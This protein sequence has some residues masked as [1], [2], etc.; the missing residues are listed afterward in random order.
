VSEIPPGLVSADSPQ[1]GSIFGPQL[2]GIYDQS[3]GIV[4]EVDSVAAVEYARDYRVSDYPQEKG[5][6]ES[7][8][9]VQ[10]PFRA[11]VSFF[12]STARYNF[13]ANIENAVASLDLFAVFVPEWSYP[14]ANLT[15]YS[16]RREARSGVTLIRVDVWCE[17]I[18]I[19]SV[20]AGASGTISR[21]NTASTNAASPQASG[22]VQAQ[23]STGAPL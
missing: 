5:G 10:V 18:R 14:S 12:I 21:G 4:L 3:G 13:L 1:V 15:H 9:K 20:S 17:E 11:I 2:W 19:V 6:F 23:S 22:T 16:Y 7:Y 8:N